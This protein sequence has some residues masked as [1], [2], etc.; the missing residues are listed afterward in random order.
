[1]Q[2]ASGAKKRASGERDAASKSGSSSWSQPKR[3]RRGA[4]ED[5]ARVANETYCGGSGGRASQSSIEVAICRVGASRGAPS[6]YMKWS[7]PCERPASVDT[8]ASTG[9]TSSARTVSF[10]QRA[11][12]SARD[13]TL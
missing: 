9:P 1:M 6:K 3:S 7:G 11:V 2:Y 5:G 13:G 4:A 10:A 12:A 8:S